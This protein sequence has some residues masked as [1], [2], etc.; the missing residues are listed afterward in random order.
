MI[1]VVIFYLLVYQVFDLEDQRRAKLDD[2]AVLIQKMIRGWLQKTRVKYCLHRSV[3]LWPNGVIY[4]CIV[5][6]DTEC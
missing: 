3:A 1:G 2:I 4:L 5:P 6:E